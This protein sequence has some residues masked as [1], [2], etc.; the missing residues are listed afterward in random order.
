MDKLRLAFVGAGYMGQNAHLLNY[1]NL[2]EECTVVALAEKKPELARLVGERCGIPHVF[3]D[4][5][6]LVASGV[7]YDA[8]V[9]AQQ[10]RNH[11]NVVPMILAQRKPLLT[12]KALCLGMDTAKKLV[13]CADK[14]GTFHMVAYHKRSDPA[15]EYAKAV[16]DEWRASGEFG[17]MR[18]VRIHMPVG[19]WQAYTPRLYNTDEPYPFYEPEPFPAGYTKEMGEAQFRFVN[20]Y[21][22]QVNYLRH[23]LGEPYELDY[24]APSGALLAIKSRSGVC[25]VLEME[26][27][28][29]KEGW[30]ETITVCFEHGSVHVELPEPLAARRS[31]TVSVMRDKAGGAGYAQAPRLPAV[32]AMQNQ[33]KNFLAAVRGEKLP[34][35]ASPE[36]AEDI[37]IATDYI[38]RMFA[39][40]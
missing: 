36:A 22:H 37:R 28:S 25:G 27:Y 29:L 40:K 1:L 4:F 17:K 31:G 26:P 38:A 12:E 35:C 11:C 18:L 6:D 23:M 7:A 32:S 16:V 10:F 13:D 2:P 5:A 19:N 3:G 9:S 24:A 20:Y 34:P 8:V 39:H 21:I 33:A 30:G 14:S 15:T